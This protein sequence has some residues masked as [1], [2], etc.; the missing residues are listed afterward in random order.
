[1][2][3]RLALKLCCG[4]CFLFGAPAI[5]ET[6]DC[7]LKVFGE[8]PNM[9]GSSTVEIVGQTLNWQVQ[10]PVIG[11]TGYP[12][13]DGNGGYRLRTVTFPYRILE[14]NDLGVSAVSSAA[15]SALPNVGTVV[16]ADVVLIRKT[17]GKLKLG[18]IGVDAYD[19]EDGHCAL[20]TPRRTN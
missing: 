2:L 14:N 5:A 4:A 8:P 19:V 9:P 3:A 6:W 17:D 13:P 16:L 18:N 1:M 12:V 15:A 11:A 10:A 20:R 7:T